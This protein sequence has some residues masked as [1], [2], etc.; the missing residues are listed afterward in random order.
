MLLV[1]KHVWHVPRNVAVVWAYDGYR[2]GAS[3]ASY[4][5]IQVWEILCTGSY[6]WSMTRVQAT[7]MYCMY[8]QVGIIIST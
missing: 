8:E 7:A 6:A 4:S 3:T 5:Y 1:H 2:Y